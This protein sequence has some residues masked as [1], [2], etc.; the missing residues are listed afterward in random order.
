MYSRIL[1]ML[2]KMP[3]IPDINVTISMIVGY[4]VKGDKGSD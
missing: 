4:H 1:T 2:L 3:T